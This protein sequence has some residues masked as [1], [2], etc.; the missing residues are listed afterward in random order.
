MRFCCSDGSMG[1]KFIDP[2][3]QS[4][5]YDAEARHPEG[6]TPGF[7]RAHQ[8]GE[9]A[10]DE[11][12]LPPRPRHE[13]GP[14]QRDTPG[15]LDPETGRKRGHR[16]LPEPNAWVMRLKVE[17]VGSDIERPTAETFAPG[18]ETA[19]EA[20]RRVR[21]GGWHGGGVTREQPIQ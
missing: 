2:A 14:G 11:R 7:P 10:A 9:Y 12:L 13:E 6:D 20:C 8:E 17:P 18:E 19:E 3:L 16:P 1:S 15:W 5:L 4:F 21:R